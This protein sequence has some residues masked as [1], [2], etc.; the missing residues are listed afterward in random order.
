[1]SPT[2]YEEWVTPHRANSHRDRT[3]AATQERGSTRR[4]VLAYHRLADPLDDAW[5]LCISPQ[6]FLEQMGVVA[7]LS[8]RGTSQVLVTFDDGYADTITTA[9]PILENQ[10]LSAT[11][12]CVSSILLG[13]TQFWWD[14][15]A[16]IV[17]S[18][19]DVP[20]SVAIE[21]SGAAF[22]WIR[23]GSSQD[24]L[25]QGW[26]VYDEVASPLHR[27]YRSLWEWL[28]DLPWQRRD[29]AMSVARSW[30]SQG[31][32]T[33]ALR[34]PMTSSELSQ[35]AN[36][37]LITIGAH[38]MTH[39]RLAALHKRDQVNEVEESVLALREFTGQQ[40]RSFAYPF[41]QPRDVDKRTI[42]AVRRSGVDEAFLFAPNP[43]GHRL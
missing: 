36:H 35:L 24:T 20:E 31:P 23:S 30:C 8:R 18:L 14:E 16:D 34:R 39:P 40:V 43:K 22:R 32:A 38:S 41:G 7:A 42:E 3:L 12:F 29:E 27:L 15:L 21:V 26:R 19:Q 6:H 28:R 2:R 9:L 17:A 37:P 11:V 5:D 33:D 25:P 4:I 13:V 10:E 1:M